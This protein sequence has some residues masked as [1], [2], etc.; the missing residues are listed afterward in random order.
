[1]CVCVFFFLKFFL[2]QK[3]DKY[4]F[5]SK[6]YIENNMSFQIFFKNHKIAKKYSW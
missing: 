3:N 4:F 6:I 2:F 5:W 1:M